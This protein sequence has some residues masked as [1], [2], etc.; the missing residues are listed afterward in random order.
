[1][2]VDC[3]SLLFTSPLCFFAFP[4]L[5]FC[6]S[7]ITS[8]LFGFFLSFRSSWSGRSLPYILPCGVCPFYIRNLDADVISFSRAF[9]KNYKPANLGY[10]IPLPSHALSDMQRLAREVVAFARQLT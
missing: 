8:F 9:D 10:P 2:P 5:L 4:F 3:Y 1:M 6:F 7:L